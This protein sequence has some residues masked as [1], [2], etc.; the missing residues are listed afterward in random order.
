MF[1]LYQEYTLKTQNTK[2][3]LLDYS[4][5]VIEK[6][7]S[8][9]PFKSPINNTIDNL[10]TNTMSNSFINN[11][12]GVSQLGALGTNTKNIN[13]LLKNNVSSILHI[14][15]TGQETISD[16]IKQYALSASTT[17]K[18]IISAI[19]IIIIFG[20]CNLISI[21]LNIIIVPLG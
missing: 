7:S 13:D 12:I 2:F 10:L 3:S 16:I 14:K 20:I 11:Y 21:L 1:V 5:F 15:I 18:Y 17:T 8:F 9:M 4:F 6:T 19:L